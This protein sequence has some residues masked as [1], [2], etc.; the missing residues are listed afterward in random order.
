MLF[1]LFLLLFFLLASKG[2]QFL[3]GGKEVICRK[4]VSLSLLDPVVDIVH[5][6]VHC[7]VF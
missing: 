1:I 4:Q 6:L 3:L 5:E 7:L 2:G